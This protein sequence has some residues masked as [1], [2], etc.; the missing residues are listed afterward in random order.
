MLL[1]HKVHVVHLAVVVRPVVQERVF[2]THT[3]TGL[4]TML[5]ST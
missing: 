2:T 3:G 5:V 1:P 4:S